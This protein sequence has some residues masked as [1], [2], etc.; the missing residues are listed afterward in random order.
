MNDPPELIFPGPVRAR[1]A[2]ISK[3]T[4]HPWLRQIVTTAYRPDLP[5]VT[6]PYVQETSLVEALALSSKSSLEQKS[7]LDRLAIQAF[8]NFV[9]PFGSYSPWEPNA[10]AVVPFGDFSSW[11][12]DHAVP[13]DNPF[14]K[15]SELS[16]NDLYKIALDGPPEWAV[17]NGIC[18]R[19]GSSA[20]AKVIDFYLLIPP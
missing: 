18:N 19:T 16:F 4:E 10:A 11:I 15:S 7:G 12:P 6:A 5:M 20:M 3:D 17:L 14:V 2:R 1:L 8:S 13:A 9:D